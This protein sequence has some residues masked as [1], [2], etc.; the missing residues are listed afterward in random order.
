M[1]NITSILI[2]A[3]PSFLLGVVLTFVFVQ[4]FYSETVNRLKMNNLQLQVNFEKLKAYKK[5][6]IVY[7]KSLEIYR[8]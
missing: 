5:P 6:D 7:R 2:I 8:N 1:D 4:A 3:I